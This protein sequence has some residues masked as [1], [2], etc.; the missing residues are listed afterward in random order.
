MSNFYASV[1][2]DS[3]VVGVQQSP[4]KLSGPN[5]VPVD[6]LEESLIGK[7]YQGG[8]FVDD[9]APRVRTRLS[10]R[11]FREQFTM[12]EKQAI[13]TAAKTNVDVE[14]WLDD[15]RSVS[16]VDL[17]FPQTVTSVQALEAAGLIGEGRADEILAGVTDGV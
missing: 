3:R 15:L 4:V 13:Y 16:Y 12:A 10:V 14:V 7:V 8:Q 1:D 11:E 5:L 6:G 17:D 2:S 9:P